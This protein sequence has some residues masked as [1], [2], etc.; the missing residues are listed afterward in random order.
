[1][2]PSE[3]SAR[4][5]GDLLLKDGVCEQRG[6]EEARRSRRTRPMC[7]R[8]RSECRAGRRVELGDHGRRAGRVSVSRAD[9]VELDAEQH[10][11]REPLEHGRVSFSGRDL[12]SLRSSADVSRAPN[13]H[14]HRWSGIDIELS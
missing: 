6:A 10:V 8:T 5:L 4:A 13:R 2:I 1:M 14:G 12:L 7:R 9:R 3:S 11:G